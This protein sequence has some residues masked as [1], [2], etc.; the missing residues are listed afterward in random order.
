MRKYDALIK[1]VIAHGE[2]LDVYLIIRIQ[3]TK[4]KYIVVNNGKTEEMAYNEVRGISFQAFTKAGGCGFAST[5]KIDEESSIKLVE[6]A[7]GLAKQ[8]EKRGAK[9]NREI[10]YQQPLVK[11]IYANIKY[12][13][14]YLTLDEEEKILLDINKE[15]ISN[16]HN[17]ALETFYRNV[18]DCWRIVRSDGTDIIYDIPRTIVASTITARGDRTASTR[19][20]L[21]GSD[22]SLLL[23]DSSKQRFLKR[24]HKACKL[25]NDLLDSPKIKGGSYKI[26][27]DYALAKGLAHEAFGHAAESDGMKLSILADEKGRYKQ[28]EV[29]ASPMVSIID[30]SIEGDYAYQPYSANGFKRNK[31][32]IVKH[33]ILKEALADI[34]SANEAGVQATGA[35]RVESY[36][37]MPVP[38]MSNIRIEV[39]QPIPLDKEIEDVEPEELYQILLE[40]KLIKPEEEVLYLV[41]YKGGQVKPSQGEFVFNC[42]GIYHLG[43]E[44][45]LHQPAIFSGKV[46]SALKSISGAVGPLLLDAQGTCGKAGQSVPSSGGSHY[47]ILLDANK[48]VIIGGE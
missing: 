31:T 21:S 46:L 33:G 12:P 32:E 40:N 36:R 7:A 11:E 13:F 22:L 27:L 45:V 2:K 16:Y 15:V 18:L 28:G 8:M 19:A 3:Q 41:G 14:D 48:D 38:R 1:K 9:P 17:I 42:S 4:T 43:K 25:A 24:T 35:E 47:F 23:E 30:E 20:A 6:I 26:I 44:C 39:E 10:F 5:E 37:Y 29:V 34:F